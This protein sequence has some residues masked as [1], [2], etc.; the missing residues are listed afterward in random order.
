MKLKEK[1]CKYCKFN[2]TE[3]CYVEQTHELAD[4]CPFY[5]GNN[6]GE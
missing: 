5:N 1:G 4:T 3:K 2:G 6:N